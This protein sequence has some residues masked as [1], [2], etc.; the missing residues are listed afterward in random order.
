MKKYM[1]DTFAVVLP[2]NPAHHFHPICIHVSLV[3][4]LPCLL[5]N[6]SLI[7]MFSPCFSP[8]WLVQ[9]HLGKSPFCPICLTRTMIPRD[10]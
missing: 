10:C 6:H 7:F 3:S 4:L 8:F 2:C 5:Q 9:R 1:P